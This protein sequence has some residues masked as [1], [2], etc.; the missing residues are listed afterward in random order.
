[1]KSGLCCLER[2]S[3]EFFQFGWCREIYSSGCSDP[4][5]WQVRFQRNSAVLEDRKHSS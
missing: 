3:I 5:N 1:L 2:R 4:C